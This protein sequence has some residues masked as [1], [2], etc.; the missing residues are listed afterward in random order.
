LTGE[1]VFAESSV[2]GMAVAH[3]T[4]QPE[5]PSKRSARAI[6]PELEAVLMRC[7]DKDRERRPRSAEALRRELAVVPLSTR[8]TRE[9]AHAWWREHLESVKAPLPAG[10]TQPGA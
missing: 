7:L 6:V 8:W 3:I 4:R 5:P 9:R 10:Q 1:H 2:M